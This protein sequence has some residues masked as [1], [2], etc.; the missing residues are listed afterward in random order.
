MS[1]SIYLIVRYSYNNGLGNVDLQLSLGPLDALQY[2]ATFS[3]NVNW[4]TTFSK[5]WIPL[6]TS[7]NKENWNKDAD[8]TYW[9]LS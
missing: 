1:Y 5:L 3:N 2:W 4:L 9:G 7:W 8:R 6:Q